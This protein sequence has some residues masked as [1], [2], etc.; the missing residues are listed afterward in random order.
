MIVMEMRYYSV[1]QNRTRSEGIEFFNISDNPFVRRSAVVRMHFSVAR[2]IYARA[3]WIHFTC[4]QQ[5]RC[6]VGKYVKCRVTMTRI[7]VM[8]I[9]KSFAP[10]WKLLT[11]L[12]CFCI[13][14][15][16]Q[17]KQR[18]IEKPRSIHYN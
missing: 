3:T 1:I 18:C 2:R 13:T 12:L 14:A 15:S 6:T 17:K 5:H 9:K 11:Y 8:N 10:C 16:N 4:I 7:D